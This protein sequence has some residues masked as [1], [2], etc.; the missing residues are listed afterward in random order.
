[1]LKDKFSKQCVVVS[2]SSPGGG[3]FF[4][5]IHGKQPVHGDEFLPG[6]PQFPLTIMLADV[7]KVKYIEYGI[8]HQSNEKYNFIKIL[9]LL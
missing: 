8:K 7:V 5:P 9:L 4:G 2:S 3:F 6:T 1:M